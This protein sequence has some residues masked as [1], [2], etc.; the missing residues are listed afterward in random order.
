MTIIRRDFGIRIQN[1][2]C[3]IKSYRAFSC[4]DI[5]V[6]PFANQDSNVLLTDVKQVL[7]K[8]RRA[9]HIVS[10]Q[11][12]TYI[13]IDITLLIRLERGQAKSSVRLELL[14]RLGS[15]KLETGELGFFHPDNYTFGDP[16]YKCRL[17]AE[18][19]KVEGLR[20]VEVLVMQR[21]SSPRTP[22]PLA[23]CSLSVA[24]TSDV[25]EFLPNEIPQLLN[26]P[27]EGTLDFEFCEH[28]EN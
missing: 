12:A 6:D 24:N 28:D 21:S 13:P 26:Q 22:V 9:G 4:V 17:V 1:A 20:S 15:D 8:Y 16:I 11:L 5:R 14:Q 2:R 3:T 27:N 10:V 18:A 25:L 23:V 19:M 7:E